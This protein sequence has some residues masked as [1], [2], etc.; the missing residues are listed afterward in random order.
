MKLR[1]SVRIESRNTFFDG[2]FA[3][4]LIDETD[5]GPETKALLR[6][7]SADE[8]HNWLKNLAAALTAYERSCSMGSLGALEEQPMLDPALV[9]NAMKRRSRRNSKSLL[10]FDW[11]KS[12][13]AKDQEKA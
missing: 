8:L 11:L 7:K 12:P 6:S 2:T 1:P 9:Q 3:F 4:A 13:K 5:S 10:K